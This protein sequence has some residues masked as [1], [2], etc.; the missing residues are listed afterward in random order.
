[1][2]VFYYEACYSDSTVGVVEHPDEQEALA[3]FALLGPLGGPDVVATAEQVTLHG[4]RTAESL[5]GLV[6]G[7]LQ[8]DR[9][10]AQPLFDSLPIEVLRAAVA[11]GVADNEFAG[12]TSGMAERARQLREAL[13][14]RE[15]RDRIAADLADM[16]RI[17]A[18]VANDAP[19][20]PAAWP[21]VSA[22]LTHR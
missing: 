1:M 8:Y 9:G 15:Q 5:P 7:Y 16:E 19:P 4:D 3:V 10:R 12:A 2:F 18:M 14:L 17:G 22:P 21:R 20:P 11:L 6:K 13:F